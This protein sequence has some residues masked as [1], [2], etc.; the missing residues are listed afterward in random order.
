LPFVEHRDA[1]SQI[2]GCVEIMGND[3]DSNSGVP[4]QITDQLIDVM[5]DYWVKAGGGFV[6]ENEI[7]IQNQRTGH[8]DPRDRTVLAE[9]HCRRRLRNRPAFA[10]FLLISLGHIYGLGSQIL[11]SL[12]LFRPTLTPTSRSVM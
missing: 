8:G 7:G 6:K 9:S 4:I 11:L 10:L 12:D 5:I 1:T 3:Q 2:K